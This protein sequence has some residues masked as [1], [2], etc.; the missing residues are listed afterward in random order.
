MRSKLKILCQTVT[1]TT[2]YVN[3]VEP[4][5]VL[6]YVINPHHYNNT[7]LGPITFKAVH[8]AYFQYF[9]QDGSTN[10]SF[11]DSY[12]FDGGAKSSSKFQKTNN[13]LH[14]YLFLTDI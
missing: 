14:I 6:F 4:R 8:E 12:I 1:F 3:I 10:S 5:V 11:D 9:K 13:P 7:T 2:D